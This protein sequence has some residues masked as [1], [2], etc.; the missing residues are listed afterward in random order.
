MSRTTSGIPASSGSSAWMTRSTPSPRTRRSPSVTSAAISMSAS[1]PRSRPVIS[2]SI[3]TRRSFTRP[4][5]S[6]RSGVVA[7]DTSATGAAAQRIAAGYAVEGGALEL[8]TV[9]VDGQVD[10]AA[11]VRIPLAMLNRHGLVAGATGTGKTK[12]LQA[13]GRAAVR[14][15]R[16]RAARRRQGRPVRDGAAGR[17]QRPD[18]V[19]GDGHRRRLDAHGVPRRVPLARRLEQRDA[20][21]RDAHPVRA[22]PAEQGARPQRHAGVDARPDLPLGRPAQPAAARHQGPARRHPAPHQR[23][24]QGGPEGHRRRL[25]GDGRGHPARAG[26]PRGRRAATTSSA[27]RSSTPRT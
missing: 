26:E 24:G 9:V 22:D 27:S 13:H 4:A 10:P 2:Q 21:P 5:Y 19:A 7:D 16:A 12:T 23:R 1:R 25:V 18:P 3:H 14:R 11:R 20:D 17:G 8:G 15:R 6:L